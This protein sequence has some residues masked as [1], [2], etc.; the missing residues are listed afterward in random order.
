MCCNSP[1][2]YLV[3]LILLPD[4]PCGSVNFLH[5]GGF[6]LI[7]NIPQTGT[8]WNRKTFEHAHLQYLQHVIGK[9]SVLSSS[10]KSWND[11]SFFCVFPEVNMEKIKTDQSYFV[12]HYWLLN[13]LQNL[14]S[15]LKAINKQRKNGK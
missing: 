8:E 4:I 3:I 2:F 5:K 6:P 11:F 10:G 12:L 14:K 9:F 1:I 13:N 15:M 7:E